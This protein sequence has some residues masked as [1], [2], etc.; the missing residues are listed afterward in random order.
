MKKH[1]YTID[2]LRVL[3]DGRF[4]SMQTI[5][6]EVEVNRTTVFHFVEI[7]VMRGMAETFVGGAKFGGVRLLRPFLFNHLEISSVELQTIITALMRTEQNPKVRDLV[8][9]LLR[10]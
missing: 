6:D 10:G 3:A 9:K 8:A 2:I 4:H 5:A 1:E 7:L